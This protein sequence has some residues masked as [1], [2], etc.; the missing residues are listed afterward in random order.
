MD[1]EAVYVGSTK[2]PSLTQD[3]EWRVVD[4][5]GG[6][7]VGEWAT[8]GRAQLEA[9]RLNERA[10]RERYLVRATRSDDWERHLQEQADRLWPA[11]AAEDRLEDEDHAWAAFGGVEFGTPDRVTVERRQRQ[12]RAQPRPKAQ[13][14]AKKLFE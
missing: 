3:C 2:R 14:T 13:G 10:G 4:L 11:F 8:E 1:M 7:T 9:D 5:E 6:G 12:R